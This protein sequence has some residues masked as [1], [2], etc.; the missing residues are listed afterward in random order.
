MFSG[1]SECRRLG[2]EIQSTLSDFLVVE[3]HFFPE[4]ATQSVQHAA[5]DGVTQAFGI[6]REPAVV[7]AHQALHP[8]R[9]VSRFTSTSA[10]TVAMV[11]LR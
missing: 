4:R 1:V 7:R 5:L 2:C 9:P 11:L 6:D 3:L 10:M 8:A